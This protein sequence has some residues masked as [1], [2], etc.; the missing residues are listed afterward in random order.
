MT[1]TKK[2]SRFQQLVGVSLHV[3]PSRRGE[4]FPS[5][6]E[7]LEDRRLLS[8][9]FQPIG[10]FPA[11]GADTCRASS[12]RS[13]LEGP[14]TTSRNPGQGPYDGADSHTYVGVVNQAIL[15][16]HPD[17]PALDRE[18]DIFGFDGDGLSRYYQGNATVGFSP[19]GTGSDPT[20]AGPGTSFSNIS[21]NKETGVVNFAD[22]SGHG[23]Y[24]PVSRPSSAWRRRRIRSRFKS[25]VTSGSCCWTLRVAVARRRGERECRRHRGQR[26]GRGQ[27]QRRQR[28]GGR[29]RQRLGDRGGFRRHRRRLHRGQRGRAHPGPPPGPDPEPAQPVLPSPLPPPPL[30]NTATVL[31]PGTYLGGLAFTGVAT[32]T[33][34]PGVY[35]MEGGG[36][37]VSGLASVSGSGVVIIN[38]PGGPRDTISV[39]QLGVLNLSAPTSGP[40]QGVAVFQDPA[41][42][43]P[44][45]FSDDANVTIAGVVYAPAVPVSITG[46]AA[47]TINPGAGT[48]T[49]PPI[50]AAMIASDLNVSG[51]GVLTINPDGPPGGASFLAAAA[52]TGGGAQFFSVAGDA[53]VT[54]GGLTSRSRLTIRRP[55][56]WRPQASRAPS[57]SSAW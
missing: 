49:L 23:L 18:H 22:N 14:I 9:N 40:Y 20:Y 44:V 4:A 53:P 48:A 8:G 31:H 5:L 30:G 41:S 46:N 13:D 28:C 19:Y 47:V 7:T 34:T 50:A 56:T 12:S 33:L 37:S 27:L 15:R 38:V 54:L 32:A 39:S 3:T 29:W 35:V 2:S 24:R 26:R 16:H 57:S 11:I 51:N 6:P 36:F 52:G 21:S 42:A 10:P 17:V 45:S 43:N 1:N 25:A 55:P